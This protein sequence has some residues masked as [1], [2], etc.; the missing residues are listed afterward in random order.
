M[1]YCRY[2]FAAFAYL[3]SHG[4]FMPAW[5][6][7][8]G[9][10][11]RAHSRIPYCRQHQRPGGQDFKPY[12]WFVRQPAAPVILYHNAPG[13]CVVLACMVTHDVYLSK[14]CQ[15][16]IRFLPSLFF[17]SHRRCRPTTWLQLWWRLDLYKTIT[18]PPVPQART[19]ALRTTR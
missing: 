2:W 1:R 12:R 15:V 8:P 6:S 3:P 18:T 14:R 7:P 19:P 16:T 4:L 9:Y 10:F 13:S 11:L 17:W 5:F